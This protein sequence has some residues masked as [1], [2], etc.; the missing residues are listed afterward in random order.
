MEH[1][2]P[3]ESRDQD[4]MSGIIA[5]MALIILMVLTAIALI[6]IFTGFLG[7]T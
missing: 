3:L 1:R 2:G 4:E 7:T 6:G 5:G